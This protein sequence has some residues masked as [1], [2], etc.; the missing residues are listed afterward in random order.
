MSAQSGK[1]GEEISRVHYF[2]PFHWYLY[3]FQV[4]PNL[5]QNKLIWFNCNMDTLLLQAWVFVPSSYINLLIYI[6]Y[7]WAVYFFTTTCKQKILARCFYQKFI[8]DL[9][10]VW[11]WIWFQTLPLTLSFSASGTCLVSLDFGNGDPV[12]ILNSGGTFVSSTTWIGTD[13]AGCNQGN[14]IVSFTH[15]ISN[16]Q[17]LNASCK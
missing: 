12:F 7:R 5:H 13:N 1:V 14:T 8:K 10:I 6:T 17:N 11:S 2:S 9:K 4:P 3:L 16:I 15:E